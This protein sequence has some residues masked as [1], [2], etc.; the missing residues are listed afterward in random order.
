M[1]KRDLLVAL[2][3]VVLTLGVTH[4]AGALVP[5]MGT[6]IFHWNE[7]EVEMQEGV[8][9]RGFA[10]TATSTLLN[11]DLRGV[12]IEPGE[13][14]HPARPHAQTEEQLVLVRQGSLR[15]ELGQI[16]PTTAGGV[17]DKTQTLGAGDVLFL[18]PNQEHSLENVGTR[19]AA[20]YAVEWRSPGMQGGKDS[21]TSQP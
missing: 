12:T 20:Y 15:V 2:A 19:P 9:T 21:L 5:I 8:H 7:A 18:A 17:E 13:T 3:A 14:P 4:G 16:R 11:L 6:S 10:S 1:T